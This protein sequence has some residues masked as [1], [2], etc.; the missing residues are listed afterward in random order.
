MQ[1]DANIHEGSLVSIHLH[2]EVGSRSCIGWIGFYWLHSSSFHGDLTGSQRICGAQ[3]EE[4]IDNTESA[5]VF[6][7]FNCKCSPYYIE[8]SCEMITI[9]KVVVCIIS[10]YMYHHLCLAIAIR[11]HFRLCFYG[12]MYTCCI[13]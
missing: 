1:L 2:E 6:D 11:H 4:R 7:G 8:V 9:I 13:G 5:R 12:C 3:T 10:A